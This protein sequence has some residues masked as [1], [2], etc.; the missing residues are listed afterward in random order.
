MRRYLTA[1]DRRVV[2]DA[3]GRDGM[4]SEFLTEWASNHF[5]MLRA[6]CNRS[7]NTSECVYNTTSSTEHEIQYTNL[8]ITSAELDRSLLTSFTS[9]RECLNFEKKLGWVYY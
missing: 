2:I 4:R 1:A 9:R 6:R 3:E 7:H 8:T 5:G